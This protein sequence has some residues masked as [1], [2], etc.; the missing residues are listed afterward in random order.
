VVY[1]EAFR[2]RL[3]WGNTCHC[4]QGPLRPVIVAP[5]MVRQVRDPNLLSIWQRSL[6]ALRTARR[7]FIIG[8]SLPGEDL[9]I[10]S[11]LMRA[12]RAH[13]GPLSV[14]AY[15]MDSKRE[16]KPRYE[17]LFPGLFYEA[18]GGGEAFIDSLPRVPQQGGT[19]PILHTPRLRLRPMEHGDLDF[20][21]G[22]LSH[23]EVMRFYPKLYS[24]EEAV[25]WIERQL[26][27]YDRHGHG[28]WLAE[29]RVTGEPCG[30]VGMMIQEVDGVEEPEIGYLIHRPFW[31]QGLA[32]EAAAT[33]RDWAFGILG[34]PR[35]ISLIRP[36]NLPS[37]GVAGKIGMIPEKKTMFRDL[38]HIVFSTR[39]A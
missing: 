32:S 10:R 15:Q 12:E 35:V 22:M 39:A 8:Y 38:E 3:D 26:G 23:P 6:E 31:R 28:L 9:A 5:S 17:L 20:I 27:Q 2:R 14:A 33:V 24:R 16:T 36:E 4:L 1:G 18:D 11:I 19:I 7:W 37:Q 25:Q 13:D 30:Q 21:A 29:D 34:L